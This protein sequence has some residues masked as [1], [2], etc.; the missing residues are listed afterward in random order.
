MVRNLH[1]KGIESRARPDHFH[2]LFSFP[3]A[4]AVAD[5]L[6]V[7]KT[8]SSVWVHEVRRRAAFAW[9]TGYGAF[10]V[11]PSNVP[12]VVKYIRNQDAHHRVMSFQEEFIAF[13]KRHG[14]PYDERY[15]WE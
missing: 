1:G 11:S 10:S 15:I 3:P 12:E 7:L 8:N 9:Q 13:L 4:L 14:I 5:A 2:G 6:R